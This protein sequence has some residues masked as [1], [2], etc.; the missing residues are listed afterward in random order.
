MKKPRSEW[1]P[2]RLAKDRASEAAYK[3]AHPRST[4]PAARLE[5]SRAYNTA[6]ARRRRLDPEY[7]ARGVIASKKQHAA[8]RAD[9]VKRARFN[10]Q[11]NERNYVKKYG[12]TRLDKL[13]LLEQQGRVCLVCGIAEPTT[14]R[15][16]HVDHDHA[17]GKVRGILCHHCN[18]AAGA[19]KDNPQTARRLADYLQ[20]GGA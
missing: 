3:A 7:R 16:W 2:E 6:Y 9:P 20:K 11:C 18:M 4:W 13:R 8:I 1:S 15:P 12:I 14:L 17:T 5:K 19:V 10:A